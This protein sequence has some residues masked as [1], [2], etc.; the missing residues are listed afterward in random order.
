[1]MCLAGAALICSPAIAANSPWSLGAG[2]AYSPNVY[3]GTS[4]DRVAI[5]IIGFEG[6]HLYLRGFSAGYRIMPRG[7]EHNVI[8]KVMYDSRSFDP[9]D[10]DDANMK[11]LDEREATVLGGISYQWLSPVGVVEAGVATDVGNKHNGLYAELAWKLPYRTPFWGLTPELGYSYND[12]K[13]NQHLYGVSKQESARTGGA[14]AAFDPSW[15]GHYFVGLS[16]YLNLTDHITVNGGVRYTNI[17]G[18]LEDSPIL[19]GTVSTKANIG[20]IYRF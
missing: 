7:S 8:L 15:D 9:S 4:S 5:P 2:A 14:I 13:L 1:M 3:K 18:E 10:S 16:A 6:E 11:K 12:D 17:E 20:I 19:D